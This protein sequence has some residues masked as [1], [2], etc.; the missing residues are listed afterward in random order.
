[1][2]RLQFLERARNTHGY[3][4][5]YP[6]LADKIKLTDKII[7]EY[8]NQCYRQSVNKHLK[9]KSPEKAV[10]KKTTQDFID[11]AKKVWG[12]K[13]DYSLTEYTGALNLIKVIYQGITY[14]QRASSHLDG[15][16]PEF[17]K[18]EAVRI[19]EMISDSDRIGEDEIESFLI[20][21]KI[22]YQ[23]H[24]KVAGV[25]FDFYLMELRTAVQ[26][27]GIQH[28]EVIDRF[29]GYDNY[30]RIV[31]LDSK[32]DKYCE[33]HFINLIRIK[34]DQFDDIYTILW[35]NLRNYIKQDMKIKI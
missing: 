29:G 20:K 33:D 34:Y 15:L 7:V 27:N 4:Y 10:T 30:L 26:Y 25:E 32:L 8:N 14:E 1:M 6:D 28:Y 11:E 35:E 13:Y 18:N 3:K 2:T 16:A 23:K 12:D 19:R 31:E 5:L 24:I 9:G 22:K 21:Y 17:R